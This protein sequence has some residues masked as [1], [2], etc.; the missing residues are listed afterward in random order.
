MFGSCLTAAELNEAL[1]GLIKAKKIG[2]ENS[3]KDKL[4][5]SRSKM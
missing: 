1:E 5:V 4:T 2:I 3:G